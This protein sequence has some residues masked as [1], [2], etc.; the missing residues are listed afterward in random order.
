MKYQAIFFDLDGTL[1][2]MDQNE[3][4]QGYFG[5]LYKKIAPLGYSEKEFIPALWKGV[6]AMVKND[7]TKLNSERFWS[8]FSDILGKDILNSI[9]VFEDFYR[10]EFNGAVAFTQPSEYAAEIVKK[11]KEK[12]QR[13]VLATNPL[14]PTV[15][16]HARIKWAGLDHNDFDYITDYDNS[17]TCKP[18][19]E[20]YREIAKKLGLDLGKCLMIGNNAEEDIQAASAAGMDTFLLTEC[21]ICQGELPECKKGSHSDLKRMLESL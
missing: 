10:N 3:F 1:L 20:Y 16:V 14:F 12:C 7:G 4:T 19:P 2:P 18:S 17:S 5:L 21:L 15:A 13:L 9:S 6:S 11:A 8:V